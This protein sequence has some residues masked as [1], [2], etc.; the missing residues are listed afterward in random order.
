MSMISQLNIDA[1]IRCIVLHEDAKF[2]PEKIALIIKKSVRTVRD[3]VSKLTSGIDIT[4]R[5]IGQ[6]RKATVT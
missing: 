5:K 3:W 6:G 1:K 2:T 4:E